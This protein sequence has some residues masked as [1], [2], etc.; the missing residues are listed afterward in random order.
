MLPQPANERFALLREVFEL[1]RAQ[2]TALEVEDIDLFHRLLSER[3]VLLNRLVVVDG[4][5]LPGNV[6]PFR[7]QHGEELPAVDDET[8]IGVLIRGILD[9]DAENE[10]LI[11]AKIGA[12]QEAMERMGK[13][14]LAAKRYRAYTG[15]SYMLDRHVG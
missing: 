13:G 15:D 11:R 4:M 12:V 2:K 1:A 10:M 5:D 8:A 7:G 6:I 9:Q 14:S 3:E